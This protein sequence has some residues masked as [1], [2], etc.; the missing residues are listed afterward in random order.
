MPPCRSSALLAAL[1]AASA[2]AAVERTASS[3]LVTET[4][5]RYWDSTRAFVGY[6]LFGAKGRTYLLDMAGRVAHIW[7][8]SGTNPRLLPYNGN[9]LDATNQGRTLLE[10][11]W[12]GSTVWSYTENRA[13]YTPHH[14]W[15]RIYNAKLGQ[16]T[17]LYIANKALDTA[18]VL[19]AGADPATGP[20]A[21]AQMDVVV[22]V[23]SLG[24]I[25]W[26]WGFFDHLVQDVDSTKANW[27]GQGKTIA[28]HPGRLDANLPGRP[29]RRDWLHCNSLDY[30]PRTG[31]VVIN[32]VQGEFYVIDHDGTFV[33]GDSAASVALA[34]STAGDFLYRFGD[35]ARYGRGDA[36]S[37]SED[38]TKS[39]WGNKQ[40]GGAHDI[41]WIEEGLPGSGDFLIFNNGQY[42][43]ESTPQSSILEIDPTRNASGAS[44]GSYVDPPSAGY[45]V[46]AADDPDQMK[47]KRLLSNQIVWKYASRSNV[48][49][50]SHIG[51]SA[52]RL[53]NG[54]TL[55]CAMTSG[56]IFEVTDEGL[57]VWE[58]IVPVT[59]DGVKSVFVDQYPDYN[60][61]FRA[62]R[63]QASHKAFQGRS[64][65]ATQTIVEMASGSTTSGASPSS[66]VASA[67]VALDPGGKVVRFH[68]DGS[69][70]PATIALSD[71]RGRTVF[72]RSG[73][74]SDVVWDGFR[75]SPGIYLA[76]I[77]QGGAVVR[78]TICL[79]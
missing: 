47:G 56:Q 34:A 72:H 15:V 74:T 1:L 39:S 11:D 60:A 70:S 79:R 38:W 25:V 6:T 73:A 37:I 50:F 52:Q 14:D 7:S 53:P 78:R 2:S 58:Y 30:D 67:R 63:Y 10:V 76:S 65:E 62:Y 29:I 32:S 28:D 16:H 8:T 71:P 31:R 12:N 4:E 3:S 44:T 36:P 27:V 26:E 42:L 54:N 22:E 20:Y 13:A 55:I 41:Q 59:R 57:V 43:F 23:D 19:A 66:T 69:A 17:T 68:L 45:T 40:I 77:R 18:A 5:L 64:L 46:W 49:F 48:D 9:L 75:Q 61:I 51:S 33:P 24:R 35:P 21:G